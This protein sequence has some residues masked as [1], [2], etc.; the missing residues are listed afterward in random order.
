MKISCCLRSVASLPSYGPAKVR[1]RTASVAQVKRSS[2]TRAA[3]DPGSDV[4][5]AAASAA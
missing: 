1:L 3:S 4:A 5:A 2:V